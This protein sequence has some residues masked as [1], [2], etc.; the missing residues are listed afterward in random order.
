MVSGETVDDSS[1]SGGAAPKWFKN[2]IV[3]I[4]S[5]IV[6][7]IVIGVCAF[8]YGSYG[9]SSKASPSP[10]SVSKVDMN[11]VIDNEKIHGS[12]VKVLT[13]SVD[14]LLAFGGEMNYFVQ[15]NNMDLSVYNPDGILG[16]KSA[17]YLAGPEGVGG[18]YQAVPDEQ[19]FTSQVADKYVTKLNDTFT[20]WTWEGDADFNRGYFVGDVGLDCS[21]PSIGD[22]PAFKLCKNVV[23]RGTFVTVENGLAVQVDDVYDTTNKTVRTITYGIT[24]AVSGVLEAAYKK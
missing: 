2:R 22:K 11:K 24:P 17:S 23:S 1:M 3:L 18:A 20:L 16:Q 6:A 5:G 21:S 19:N 12:M 8:L 15:G 4:I 9:S 7:I 13:A 10:S 14:K